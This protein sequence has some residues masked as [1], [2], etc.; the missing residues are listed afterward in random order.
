M[1]LITIE[2][3]EESLQRSLDDEEKPLAAYYIHLISTYV[4]WYTG[5]EVHD[6][7]D[8]AVT[9]K[10]KANYYGDVEIPGAVDE[11]V[12]VTFYDGSTVWSWHFD[13][14]NLVFGLPPNAPVVVTYRSGYAEAP[15]DLKLVVTEAV[16]RL[17]LD[18]DVDASD[19]LKAIQ[20]G[21]VK[22]EYATGEGDE[23]LGI[24]FNEFERLILK[25]YRGGGA[26]TL[27]LGYRPFD[28]SPGIPSSDTALFE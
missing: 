24:Y 26:S 22:E 17:F 13:G 9:K 25:S 27:R 5:V 10:L 19:R 4:T 16:K 14:D 21:D 12:D 20:V 7:S 3:L 8:G 2:D 23:G 1:D 6:D 28:P 18:G 15:E 11:V